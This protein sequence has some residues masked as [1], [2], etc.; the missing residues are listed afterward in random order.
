[1][2]IYTWLVALGG[3]FGAATSFIK[4]TIGLNP[5]ALLFALLTPILLIYGRHE[6]RIRRLRAIKDFIRAFDDLEASAVQAE[7]DPNAE[8]PGPRPKTA[9]RQNPSFEFVKSKYISDIDPKQLEGDIPFDSMKEGEQIDHIIAS[10]RRFGSSAD[11]RIFYATIG[12]ILTCYFGFDALQAT[13]VCGF[14]AG[15][16]NCGTSANCQAAA[17]GV[18]TYGQLQI[19]GSLAFIGAYIAAVR[20]FLRGLA[21]FDLSAFTFLR[22]T[23]EIIASVLLTVLLYKASPDPFYQL[24][25]TIESVT[26]P[27]EIPWIWYALAPLLGLLPQSST[28]FL[29][30]K[31]Q[32]FFSWTK[33]SDDRFLEVTRI[34]SLDIIDGIDYETRFRLE[35]CGIFDVQNLAAYNPIMLHI[36][37]P[38]NIYQVIDWIAQSQLCHI[39]GPEKF[40]LFREINIRTIFDLE[41][42]IS[43]K[44]S[45]PEFDDICFSILF[46][47][48]RNLRDVA[49]ISESK[50]VIVVDGAAKEV[51]VEDYTKWI[52]EKVDAANISE[53][54]EHVMRW[55]AD[56]LHVRRLRRLWKEISDSL[57]EQAKRLE[58]TKL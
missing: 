17:I 37:S 57:G 35:E 34:N 11:K 54:A 9:I 36:E 55:I 18:G 58:D 25:S 14:G 21:V 47:S 56:D 30:V 45:P 33:T 16:C 53:A 3:V 23:A 2:D 22:Q 5:I 24:K 20:I 32:S 46:T 44:D 43:D 7:L 12:L 1:M 51:N 39:V 6:V 50:F 49:R 31:L 15:G 26:A 41:R 13:I 28:K 4:T 19:I 42:A 52:R 8:E 40:L 29:L 10:A 48:T 38:Y 27:P